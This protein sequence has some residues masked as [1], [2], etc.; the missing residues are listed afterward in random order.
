MRD[1]RDAKAMARSLRDA[2]K[3]KAIE[4]T[5]TE[6]LELIAKAFGYANWNTLSAK[7][8]AAEPKPSERSLSDS[9][10]AVATART[11]DRE[12][13]DPPPITGDYIAHPARLA[14]KNIRYEHR[15]FLTRL[16]DG[17]THWEKGS[18][19]VHLHA[20]SAPRFSAELESTLYRALAYANERKHEYTTLEHLLLALIDDANASAMMKACDVDPGRLTESLANYIDNELKELAIDDGRGTRPTAGF[21]RVVQRAVIQ[22]QG[23]GR[24]TVTGAELLA[25][26]FAERESHAAYFLQEQAMTRDDGMNFIVHGIGKGGGGASSSG[27]PRRP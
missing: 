22:T 7:I 20:Q 16:P 21:Q 4:T 6:A 13:T 11:G 5:H 17:L 27:R 19:K 9:G 24:H 2:L 25:N 18:I 14:V 23:L 10:A 3:A 26:I 15:G 8:E 12:Q 1:F